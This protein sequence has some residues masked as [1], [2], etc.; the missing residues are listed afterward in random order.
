MPNR[1]ITST[2]GVVVAALA[3]TA[4]GDDPVRVEEQPS[5]VD[6]ASDAGSFTTLLAAL[7]VAGLTSTLRGEGPFTVFAPSDDAF[8]R[9][10]SDALDGLL[11][12]RDLLTA[13]LT[14]HVVPGRVLAADVLNLT[15]APTV[16]G[17]ALTISVVDGVV[18]VDGAK[19]VSTDIEAG[20]GVIHV[21]DDVLAPQPIL[22]LV[23]TAQKAGTFETLI[24]AVNAAGLTETL[25]G[26]GPFTIFAPTD[27]AF[28]AL[29]AG[30]LEALLADPD[31]LAA[32]LTYHV[33]ASEV[34]AAQVVGLTSATT[35][36]GAD[37]SIST[38]G[39]GVMVNDADVITTDVYATN[40]VI[41][42]IDKVLLPPSE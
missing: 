26:A 8:A 29:P 41:H 19:V 35:V 7:D 42:V 10:P 22:D 25:R 15:S 16:N 17:K 18:M 37:V 32:V 11:A 36:N 21:I 24:V 14:Y 31:A 5:I 40:G 9:I 1:T 12:N 6:V 38:S 23:Q 28:A 13:V 39:G 30:T 27:E 4:C 3:L 34:P 33:V 20:N 2:A